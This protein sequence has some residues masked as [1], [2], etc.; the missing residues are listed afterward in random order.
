MS[1][2]SE[3]LVELE[4]QDLRLGK[5]KLP[6]DWTA[7]LMPPDEPKETFQK[8]EKTLHGGEQTLK[9]TAARGSRSEDWTAILIWEIA[10]HAELGLPPVR[11]EAIIY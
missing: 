11:E 6:A 2:V 9:L 4:K 10:L 7:L 1:T 5:V 3:T 8:I